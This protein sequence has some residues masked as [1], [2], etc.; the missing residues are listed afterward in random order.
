MPDFAKKNARK[1]VLAVDE[2]CSN[3][4]KYAYAGDTTK[5]IAI[6]VQDSRDQFIVRLI[7]SARRSMLRR[8]LRA[9]LTM[10]GPAD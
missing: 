10:S 3:I 6:T 9:I 1:I 5:T 2:A 4:I 8:S 7:D